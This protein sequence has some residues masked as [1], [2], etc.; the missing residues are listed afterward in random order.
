MP[1]LHACSDI[2]VSVQNADFRDIVAQSQR[3]VA[4]TGDVF[5]PPDGGDLG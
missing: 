3:A 1:C 2:D 4:P 5:R